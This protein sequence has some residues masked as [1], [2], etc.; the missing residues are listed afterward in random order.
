MRRKNF[1]CCQTNVP[2]GNQVGAQGFSGTKEN[3]AN[4]QIEL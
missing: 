1:L 3:V 4:E 2:Q